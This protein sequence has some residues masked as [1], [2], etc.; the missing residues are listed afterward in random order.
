V[1]SALVAG[2]VMYL[3][4]LFGFSGMDEEKR[5]ARDAL[6]QL[7]EGAALLYRRARGTA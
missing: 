6:S 3:L 2:G 4:V 7:K 1:I 5:F